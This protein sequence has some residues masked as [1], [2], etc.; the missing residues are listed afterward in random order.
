MII[1]PDSKGISRI[2]N[3]QR[4]CLVHDGQKII[5]VLVPLKEMVT[6]HTIEVFTIPQQVVDRVVALGLVYSNALVVRALELGCVVPPKMKREMLSTVWQ[7]SDISLI[8]R[9]EALGYTRPEGAI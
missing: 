4:L 1:E 6:K 5:K 8:E 2:A 7:D 9:V 3:T